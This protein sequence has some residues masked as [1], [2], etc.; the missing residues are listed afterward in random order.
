MRS[1]Q[2]L[3][4]EILNDFVNSHNARFA[5]LENCIIFHADSSSNPARSNIVLHRVQPDIFVNILSHKA[6]LGRRL[7]I[8]PQN[9]FEL[10][11]ARG[12]DIF[13]A[14]QYNLPAP[15]GLFK[16]GDGSKRTGA[17]HELISIAKKNN[18]ISLKL[19]HAV[20][21][22][23]TGEK[24]AIQQF[25]RMF[26]LAL[27]NLNVKFKQKDRAWVTEMFGSETHFRGK[28]TTY[29]YFDKTPSCVDQYNR[30][31]K[32]QPPNNTI[33][34]LQYSKIKSWSEYI[35][36]GGLVDSLEQFRIE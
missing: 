2:F 13:T 14:S 21:E 33:K 4:S 15:D 18:G 20:M 17:M 7:Q 8:K 24:I 35:T 5:T 30:I 11:Q 36:V 10:F 34:T 31:M 16:S 26:Q 12:W 22:S 6:G 27:N 3:E 9:L 28:Q 29:F 19:V 32:E 1:L 23:L 25:S